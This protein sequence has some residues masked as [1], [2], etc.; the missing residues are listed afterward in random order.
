MRARKNQ[1]PIGEAADRLKSAKSLGLSFNEE[2]AAIAC[3]LERKL[4][5]TE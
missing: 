2:P 1:F 5:R 4:V 3:A